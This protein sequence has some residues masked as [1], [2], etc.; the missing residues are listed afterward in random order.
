MQQ[1]IPPPTS[2]GPHNKHIIHLHYSLP[3]PFTNGEFPNSSF[4]FFFFFYF[5]FFFIFFSSMSSLNSFSPPPPTPY[6]TNLGFGYSIAIALGVLFLIST[7]ILSSYL[8][9]RT[10]RHRNNNH[11]RRRHNPHAPD[12]IVLPRVIFVAED[13]DDGARQNDAVSGLEQ[14]VINSYPK[15]PFAK[16]GG[17]DTTC[18]ICLCEYK[19][20][21]MLRMMPECRHYF[22]LCC[23]DPWLKLNGSCPVCRN[24]PMPTPLSTPLQEVVPLSQYAADARGRR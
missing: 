15:F 17:Y 10:L 23:L 20:S 2:F 13:D 24:S 3:S 12:G 14:S 5:F 21:E 16:D 11:R 7:L 1:L 9:C 22:H 6:F 19:D 8:C 4:F 18:S